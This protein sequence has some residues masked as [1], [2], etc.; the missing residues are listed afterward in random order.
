MEELTPVILGGT[1]PQEN[2]EMQTGVPAKHLHCA[3]A[4]SMS[5]DR[6]SNAFQLFW[7]I[8]SRATS[9]QVQIIGLLVST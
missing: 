6:A 4:E 1:N 5:F 2:L 9:S 3:A 8:S 7:I